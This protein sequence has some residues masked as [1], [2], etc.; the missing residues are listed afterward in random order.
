MLLQVNKNNDEGLIK[1]KDK[2][3]KTK[4][5]IKKKD[6]EQKSQDKS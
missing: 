3:H 4:V 1:T 5:E 2:S 6:K